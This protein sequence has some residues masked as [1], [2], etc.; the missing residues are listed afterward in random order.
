MRAEGKSEIVQFWAFQFV[1][2]SSFHE[3]IEEWFILS[4]DKVEN[5]QYLL[6]DHPS[7]DSFYDSDFAETE[8]PAPH[9]ISQSVVEHADSEESQA[10]TA[11]VD[12][13]W[14]RQE[15]FLPGST[16]SHF[17]NIYAHIQ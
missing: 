10:E 6:Q 5:L 11:E 2:E 3:N 17:L 13:E 12:G 16:F 7:S 9:P 1:N 8:A 14:G 15:I 4:L